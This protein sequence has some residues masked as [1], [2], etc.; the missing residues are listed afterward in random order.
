MPIFKKLNIDN[1]TPLHT[2]RTSIEQLVNTSTI[3]PPAA[4]K[5]LFGSTQISESVRDTLSKSMDN[6]QTSVESIATDL[7]MVHVNKVQKDD[8][9]I[10]FTTA[11]SDAAVAAGLM[12]VMLKPS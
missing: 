6:L 5:T 4:V 3:V 10:A 2:L 12:G 11:Q 9:R 1:E 8:R 7:N